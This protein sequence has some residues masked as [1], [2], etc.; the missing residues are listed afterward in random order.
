MDVDSILIC[1]LFTFVFDSNLRSF[2]FS[3]LFVLFVQFASFEKAA[4]I[5]EFFATRSKPAIART[6]KQSLERVH[7]NAKWVQNVQ[8]EE[9]L[10]EAAKELAFRK[11]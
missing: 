5:E 7:I 4:E 1:C 9:H 3:L 6:L 2:L 10:A 11:Y 8:N